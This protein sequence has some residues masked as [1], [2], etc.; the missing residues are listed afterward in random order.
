MGNEKNK[1]I[2]ERK[3][4]D[5]LKKKY[6][7]F[8]YDSDNNSNN[9]EKSNYSNIIDLYKM[10]LE[11]A[12]NKISK[13]KLILYQLKYNNN[14][15]NN[16]NKNT[17]I[18]YEEECDDSEDNDDDEYNL[19]LPGKYHDIKYNLLKTVNSNDGKIIKIYDKNKKEIISNEEKKE[20]YDDKYEIFILR[21][22]ILNKILKI[23]I[24][25]F[26]VLIDK[27]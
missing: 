10:K 24:N 3:K 27:K 1:L 20:I 6:Q 12:N 23:S 19:V 4:L 2:N 25:K 16:N 9:N 13:L 7:E 8:N 11:E 18:N 5:E 15:K 22:E 14:N 21:M 17:I 26:I